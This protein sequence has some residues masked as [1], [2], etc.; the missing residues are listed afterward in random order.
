[1]V[2][3]DNSEL[4]ARFLESTGISEA[5]RDAAARL[6]ANLKQQMAPALR[7]LDQTAALLQEAMPRTR[8]QAEQAE[9]V[10]AGITADPRQRL[11]AER[12]ARDLQRVDLAG[13]APF[14]VLVLLAV[15]LFAY[16]LEPVGSAGRPLYLVAVLAL[17]SSMI[18]GAKIAGDPIR[19]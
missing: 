1:M 10:V 9:Q 11:V 8:E 17:I 5:T 6:S 2:L 14:A 16:G 19:D 13:M 3:P 7:D 12:I 15:V 18:S 4:I